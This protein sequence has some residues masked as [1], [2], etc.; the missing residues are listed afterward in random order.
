MSIWD[1]PMVEKW[2]RGKISVARDKRLIFHFHRTQVRSKSTLVSN[3]LDLLTDNLVETCCHDLVETSYHNSWKLILDDWDTH[4]TLMR[5]SKN[6]QTMQNMQIMKKMQSMQN[7]KNIQN[8]QIKLPN[9]TYQTKPTKHNPPK[10]TKTIKANQI[11]WS[12]ANKTSLLN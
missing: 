12:K 10:L 5:M 11:Y 4:P 6:M 8:M 9:Q 1:A 7:M 2:G 3:W